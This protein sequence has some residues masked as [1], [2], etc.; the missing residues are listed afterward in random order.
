M[1]GATTD[2]EWNQE[3]KL[4]GL[5]H[6]VWVVGGG[7]VWGLVGGGWVVGGETARHST[8]G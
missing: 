1:G 2:H 7:L 8:R 4:E 5:F 3:K 6:G